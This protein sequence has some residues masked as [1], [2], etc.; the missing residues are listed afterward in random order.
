MRK[1]EAGPGHPVA[2]HRPVAVRQRFMP[3]A[4]ENTTFGPQRIA[5]HARI[6]L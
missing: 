3:S 1:T 4:P 6:W 2:A 5:H